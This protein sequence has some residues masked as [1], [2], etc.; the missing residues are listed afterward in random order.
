MKTQNEDLIDF[1]CTFVKITKH[2][3]GDER[4]VLSFDQLL[5]PPH[6]LSQQSDATTNIKDDRQTVM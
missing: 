6:S 5:P 4:F 2:E 3:V 1:R